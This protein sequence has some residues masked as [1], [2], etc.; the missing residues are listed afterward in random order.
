[1]ELLISLTSLFLNEFLQQSLL[2]EVNAF[3]LIFF[4]RKPSKIVH[5][6]FILPRGWSLFIACGRREGVR[7]SWSSHNDKQ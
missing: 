5:L 6:S 7:G 3:N 4:G 2:L 1:M